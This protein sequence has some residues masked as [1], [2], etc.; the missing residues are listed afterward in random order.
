MEISLYCLSRAI[1]SFFTCM[2]D[3]GFCPPASKLKRSD[4]V[5]FSI[6]TAVIMHCYAQEREVFRSKYL[7]VLDWVFG[8]PPPAS[9]EELVKQC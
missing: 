1:E 3:A 5:V 4:V 8:I 9:N 2:S 7:N 6:A